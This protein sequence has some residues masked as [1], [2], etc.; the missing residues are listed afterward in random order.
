MTTSGYQLRRLNGPEIEPV[1]RERA[2][3]QC[4]VDADLTDEDED[5]DEWI[6][7][8]R[9]LAEDYT[10]RTLCESQWELALDDFPR[11]GDR[12][13]PLPMGTPLIA[14]TSVSYL[15]AEGVRQYITDFQA[16][17][18]EPAWIAP[19]AG[20]VWPAAKCQARSVLVEFWS[21]YRG[22]GSPPD[23]SAIPKKAKQAILML[24]GHWYANRESV[25]SSSDAR[26]APVEVP[27]SFERALDPLKVYP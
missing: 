11:I 24:V 2:K 25:T 5:F 26:S 1:T 3:R 12:R 21:G 19:A 20:S 6:A 13:I 27:Y 7:T 17:E 10:H 22:A 16:A 18:D 15:D 14:V 23:A 4:K 9:E 8:A